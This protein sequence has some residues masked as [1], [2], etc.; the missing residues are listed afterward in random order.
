LLQNGELLF[1]PIYSL[2][3]RDALERSGM[4]PINR[5]TD[6]LLALE[7]CLIGPFCH[8]DD[9]LAMRRDAREP[10]NVRIERW[11][12]R[13]KGWKKQGHSPISPKIIRPVRGT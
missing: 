5:W 12:R 7:L 1:D 10:R 8:L 3:R 13:N 6:R 2:L 4:L 9:F 11:H